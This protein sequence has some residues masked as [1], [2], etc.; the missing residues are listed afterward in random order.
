MLSEYPEELEA[1]FAS[2]YG[3]NLTDLWRG[4]L[5]F[6]RAAVL[7]TQLPAGSR[8][9]QATGGPRAWS[10]EYHA[11]MVV[12]NRVERL[13]WR[14]TEDGAK[15]KNPPGMYETPPFVGDEQ[16]KASRADMKAQRFIQR[17]QAIQVRREAEADSD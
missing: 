2:E 8:L 14:K 6:R 10:D 5:S 17:Q 13:E 3:L 11:L 9:W 7:A 1:D 12:A 16:A 4:G 15:G